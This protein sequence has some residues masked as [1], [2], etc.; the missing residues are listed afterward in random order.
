MIDSKDKNLK[1]RLHLINLYF[2][3]FIECSGLC[4]GAGAGRHIG[5]KLR[6]GGEPGMSN[7]T[8]IRLYPLIAYLSQ[9]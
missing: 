9:V 4:M 5:H 3:M 2:C 1:E 7:Q 8:F 6:V